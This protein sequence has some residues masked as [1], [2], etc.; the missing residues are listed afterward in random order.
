MKTKDV[1][2][3][4]SYSQMFCQILKVRD[5]FPD[6][7]CAG[8]RT[9]TQQHFSFSA[10]TF[11]SLSLSLSHIQ[12]RESLDRFSSLWRK[13]LTRCNMNPSQAQKYFSHSL[14]H[15]WTGWNQF[16]AGQ[17][18]EKTSEQGFDSNAGAF[19]LFVWILS[20]VTPVSLEWRER[21]LMVSDSDI[22]SKFFLERKKRIGG[23][24]F[25]LP[26][27]D[28]CLQKGYLGAFFH[29]ISSS[30]QLSCRFFRERN[31][32]LLQLRVRILQGKS[33]FVIEVCITWESKL[34]EKSVRS[35][36]LSKKNERDKKVQMTS[37]FSS[38]VKKQ[39][40]PQDISL[41]PSLSIFPS[42]RR[43]YFSLHFLFSPSGTSSFT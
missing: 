24:S 11:S 32:N 38:S 28:H 26:W 17:E 23:K 19:E 27:L 13:Q 29:L 14:P 41:L 5:C 15:S 18:K 8:K 42:W 2:W 30:S 1:K 25:C 10:R 37:S 3:R 20:C 7:I 33:E 22:S 21:S 16:E 4:K 6:V 35:R 36:C 12:L 43:Q 34:V 39:I 31:L 40:S 9:E